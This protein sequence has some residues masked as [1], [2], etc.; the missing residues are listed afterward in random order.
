M[1]G[2]VC[3]DCQ[4]VVGDSCS[5]PCPSSADFPECAGCVDGVRPVKADVTHDLLVPVVV[6]V[7]TTL[8]AAYLAHKL[9]NE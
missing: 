4:I 1:L 3:G 8:A 9:L 5:S 6:G 2:D 7:L